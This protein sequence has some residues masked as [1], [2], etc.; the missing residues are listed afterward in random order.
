KE[1]IIEV[2]RHQYTEDYI[3]LTKDFYLKM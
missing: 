3:D 2:D 1:L